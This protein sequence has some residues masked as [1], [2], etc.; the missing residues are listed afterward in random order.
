[1][2]LKQ[3]LV[4]NKMGDGR[5]Q[6]GCMLV[7]WEGGVPTHDITPTDIRQLFQYLGKLWNGG[8][9]SE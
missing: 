6:F 2:D 5:L 7:P 8:S 4:T 9:I 1:M 3:P